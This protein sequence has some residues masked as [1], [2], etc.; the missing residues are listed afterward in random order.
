MDIFISV[1][2]SPDLRVAEVARR[3]IATDAAAAVAAAAFD[4][5]F[6][7]QAE[8]IRSASG[9]SLGVGASDLVQIFLSPGTSLSLILF[10]DWQAKRR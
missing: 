4:A 3:C 9:P 6:R 2:S 8:G 5:D 1:C 10:M 7:L